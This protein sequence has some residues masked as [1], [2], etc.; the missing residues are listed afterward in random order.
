MF[1]V[2][3]IT[4][5]LNRG[6][7]GNYICSIPNAQVFCRFVLLFPSA[8]AEQYMG[9][10]SLTITLL[11]LSIAFKLNTILASQVSFTQDDLS[12]DIEQYD[13]MGECFIKTFMVASEG[14]HLT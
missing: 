7:L 1:L 12:S 11:Q 4:L 3:V 14:S 6:I 2:Y 10:S 13:E 5:F 9:L 8:V